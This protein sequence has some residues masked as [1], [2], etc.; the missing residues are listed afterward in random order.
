MARGTVLVGQERV[1]GAIEAAAERAVHAY[2]IVGAAGDQPLAAARLL[3]A[4]LVAN[5]D[6]SE[7]L[8]AAGKH[9]DVVE[10]EPVGA[11][12]KVEQ[13]REEIALEASRAPV[14]GE[15]KVLIVLEAERM[16]SATNRGAAAN[17][18]LKTL[19]EPPPRTT[20]ILVASSAVDVLPTVRSRCT[21]LELTTVSD[22]VVRSALVDDADVVLDEASLARVVSLSAGQPGRARHLATDLADMRLAF[23]SAPSALDG[24]GATV[25]RVVSGL[26]SALA[27]AVAQL[28]ASQVKE[29]A[30]FD[31]TKQNEGY[32]VRA[33]R[34]ERKKLVERQARQSRKA[35][36]ELLMEGIS[37]IESVI[38]DSLSGIDQR[39]SDVS[40]LDWDPIRCGNA[41]DQCRQARQALAIN[42]KGTLHL[43]RLLLAI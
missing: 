42:E 30:D 10:F 22:E 3:A 9:C 12:Y 36:I 35:R 18:F 20:I 2:L 7:R 38:F 25:A 5:D 28:E 34:S 26:E 11:V 19:E 33:V 15:R 16:S 32:D 6:R 40:K 29:L 24:S 8:V 37:A 31:V 4:R 17:A 27:N 1:V 43:E 23:A 13:I 14:E 41:L 39:N 21:V